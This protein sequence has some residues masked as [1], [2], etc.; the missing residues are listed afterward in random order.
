MIEQETRKIGRVVS[1]S[2][3][4]LICLLESTGGENSGAPSVH[5]LEVGTIVKMRTQ[6]SIVFGMVRAVSIPIPSSGAREEE[7]LTDARIGADTVAHGVNVGPRC[8]AEARELV[9]E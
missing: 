9:H 1:V 7:P 3:S 5:A 2:G 8:V 4:Q 6:R